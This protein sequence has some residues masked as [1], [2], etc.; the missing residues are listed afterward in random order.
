MNTL[1]LSCKK[2]TELIEKQQL[3]P[4]RFA[5]R[6]QLKMHKKVCSACSNYEKQSVFIDK[7]LNNRFT[8]A[9]PEEYLGTASKERII[10]RLKNQHP[11]TSN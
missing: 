4:L 2:A 8:N 7:A 11:D 9:V 3:I 5:E 6:L 10:D 1:M